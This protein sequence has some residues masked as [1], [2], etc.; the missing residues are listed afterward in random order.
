MLLCRP[1]FFYIAEIAAAFRFR[2][3]FCF[4]VIPI[5]FITSTCNYLRL[6]ETK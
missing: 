6:K 5:V 2:S 1:V 3:H 4:S